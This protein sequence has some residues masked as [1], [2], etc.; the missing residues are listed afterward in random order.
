MMYMYCLV[1]PNEVFRE[2]PT[3]TGQEIYSYAFYKRKYKYVYKI[4]GNSMLI[5]R[6]D[7][8]EVSLTCRVD[9]R[10]SVELPTTA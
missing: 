1:S 4:E 9:G 10:I 5:M 8:R 6:D 7:E 3:N 2:I